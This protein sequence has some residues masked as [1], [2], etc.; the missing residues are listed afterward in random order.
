[1]RIKI[2]IAD[3]QRI[4]REGLCALF[5]GEEDMEVIGAAEDGSAVVELTE[6]L[7]PDVVLMGLEIPGLNPVGIA[8]R[9]LEIKPAVRVIGLSSAGVDG[10]LVRDFLAAGAAGFITKSNGF[11]DFLSAVRLVMTK[12][13]YL[14][15]DV[16]EVM[17]DQYIRR[18]GPDRQ[19]MTMAALTPR[20]RDVLQL[21]AEG[22]S[23]KEAATALKISAKTVDMHR[24]NIM[25]KL[26]LHSIAELTKYAIR[27]GITALH[28]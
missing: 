24:Q 28:F 18:P 5:K 4:G 12:R 13:I 19:N 17:V 10:Q 20:E 25:N 11:A 15:P 1:L 21:V 27:Q 26:S 7:Y 3:D 6:S 14:S 8:R 9:V 16:A 2:L 22:M 23:T